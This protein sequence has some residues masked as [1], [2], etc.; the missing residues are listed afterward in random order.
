[1]LFRSE[2]FYDSELEQQVR[3]AF[4]LTG[5]AS[6][7]N[8][9]VHDAMTETWHRWSSI[10]RPGAYLNRAVLNRCRDQLR[11]S[12]VRDRS[13]ALIG[14]STEHSAPGSDQAVDAIALERA[15]RSLPFNHRAALVLR[16]YGSATTAEIAEALDC[17][18]G[19]VGVWIKRGLNTLRKEIG[20]A[21]V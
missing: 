7:A 11:R 13:I 18:P 16:F 21:H 5:S 1:M 3:R 15:L 6:A 17:R 10:D 2:R 14:A 12:N 9:L 8:D 4:V 20:R 19:S